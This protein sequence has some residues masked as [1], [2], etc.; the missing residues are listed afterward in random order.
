MLIVSS[1]RNGLLEAREA[2]RAGGT[3]LDA[4]EAGI[5]AVESDPTDHSVG[6]SGYPNIVGAVELDACIMDGDSRATGAV[7]GLTWCSHPISVARRVM[8]D[9]PHVLLVGAGADRF[10]REAGFRR[11]KLLSAEVRA[12]WKR[13]LAALA[14]RAGS[15]G[16]RRSRSLRQLVRSAANPQESQDTVDFIAVDDGGRMACGVSTSGWAWKFPGRAGD[17][18]I[19]GAGGYAD[20]RY[21]A[22]ACTGRGELAIRTCAARSV[23]L[24]LKMGMEVGAACREALA[25]MAGLEDPWFGW[26]D[27]IAVNAKG[28]PFGASWEKG[29]E[30]FYIN[31]TMS[32]P[33]AREKERLALQWPAAAPGQG[34]S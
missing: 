7:A 1:G 3:A 27:I 19:V 20:S 22:A 6:Y 17:S 12:A 24:L 32:S 34:R 26:V 11:E 29:H 10:A 15:R 14:P 25:D 9:L 30:L 5:R 2:L 31:D 13:R 21:G 18:P 16:V 33:G 4:V 28:E 8:E 23:V